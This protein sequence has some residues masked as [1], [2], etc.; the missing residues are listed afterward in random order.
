MPGLCTFRGLAQLPLGWVGARQTGLVRVFHF[1][2]VTAWAGSGLAQG[3]KMGRVWVAGSRGGG[4]YWLGAAC[5]SSEAP[6]DMSTS[7]GYHSNCTSHRAA[8]FLPPASLH[9]VSGS[10]LLIAHDACAC[11]DAGMNK[12]TASFRASLPCSWRFGGAPSSGTRAAPRPHSAWRTACSSSRTDRCG[13]T[14]LGLPWRRGVDQQLVP[15]CLFVWELWLV[16]AGCSG[17]HVT[18]PSHTQSA[19][20]SI[21]LDDRCDPYGGMLHAL[22]ELARISS[23]RDRATLISSLLLLFCALPPT[24]CSPASPSVRLWGAQ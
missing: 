14:G 24:W 20:S 17:K 12:S 7:L 3:L 5:R 2:T 9:R 6:L 11:V 16:R 19:C 8:A 15:R 1:S 10:T 21:N 13:V 23:S 22:T 18:A 4:P